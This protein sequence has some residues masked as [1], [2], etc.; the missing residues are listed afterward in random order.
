MIFDRSLYR[1][2]AVQHL[3]CEKPRAYFVPYDSKEKAASDL[4]LSHSGRDHSAFFQTLC[5]EWQF[6]WLPAV[7]AITDLKKELASL[8][9]TMAVPGCWQL[10]LDRGYDVP[11]YTNINYPFPCDPPYLPDDVPCGLYRRTFTLREEQLAGKRTYI[12][13]EGVDSCFYLYVNG[14]FVA[15]SQVS[16]GTSEVDLTPYV[17]VGDNEIALVVVK[18]CDGSYLEDQDKFRLSG[19]FR[20]VYLLFR[21]EAHLRDV[22]LRPEVS[23][24]YRDGTLRIELDKPTSLSVAYELYAPDGAL[25]GEGITDGDVATLAVPQVALWN[26]EEPR[27]YTLYLHSGNEWLK[28]DLGFRKI[29]VKNKTVLLNGKKFKAKGVNRHDSHPVLGYVTPFDHMVNDLL[30]MKAHNINMVRTSHYPNDPRFPA[31]CDLLGIYLCDEADIETHGMCLWGDWGYTTN[32]DDWT[33]SYLDRAERLL[34]RDKN[35]AS[36]IM[37]S[38][39]NE[40]GL[41]KNHALMCE[42]FNTRDGSRLT[43]SEDESA[44][45]AD[46]LKSEDPEVRKQGYCPYVSVQSRMYPSVEECVNS[47]ALCEEVPTPL[48]LCE[49]SHAMG[50]GPGDLKAYWDAFYA[51]DSLFGG[52]VWEFCDHAVAVILPDGR[53][54]YNYGGDFGEFPHDGN[55][56]VDGLVS[57]DRRPGSGMKELKAVLLPAEFAVTDMSA[58]RFTLTSRRFFTD[59]SDAFTLHYF[60]EDNGRR[61]QSGT[62]SLSAAPWETVPFTVEGL[63][64]DYKGAAYITF[65]LIYKNDTPWAKAGDSAGFRQLP[66][67]DKPFTLPTMTETRP[68]T[69]TEEHDALSVASG[70]N[71][72]RFDLRHGTLTSLVK[73]GKELLAAPTSLTAWRAPTDNDRNIR[74]SWDHHGYGRLLSSCRRVE[75][76]KTDASV[77]LTVTIALSP[78]SAPAR[79][80]SEVTYTVDA[81]GAL[82]VNINTEVAEGQPPLPRFGMIFPLV[83]GHEILRYFGYGPTDSYA[84]KKW[85]TRRSLFVTTV[86]DNYEHALRPQESGNHYG[87]AMAE[88]TSYQGKGL[89]I[90]ADKSFEFTALHYDEATLTSTAHDCDLLPAK[91]TFLTVCYRQAGIGSNSCGPALDPAYKISEK[92]FS[93]AFTLRPL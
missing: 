21:D 12:N 53:I 16:H 42:Y 87:T 2:L 69:V 43:H 49:Y 67:N 48:Y 74:F 80:L 28:F 85:A 34:E 35:H 79:M 14:T 56:C 76:S 63:P 84:D 81:T 8:P 91:E 58:G 3:N 15:Y 20:E 33:P 25:L 68:L 26:D 11:Q 32:S 41:G 31:L 6:K 44:R 19:I 38:V 54:K 65:E 7:D 77:S 24:D 29:E 78:L 39:G 45:I 50:N 86:T 27:L 71:A 59:L 30:L 82:T 55:F 64:A 66:L 83:E 10:Q 4:T 92:S 61:V 1:S 17:K 72:Y 70:N 73:E 36:I 60:V 9:D 89:R 18:W 51:H 5:G 88:V 47:Y 90:T 37:W 40:S 23:D 62:L 93:F 13:F 52:C 46:K 75:V 57:P 22:F